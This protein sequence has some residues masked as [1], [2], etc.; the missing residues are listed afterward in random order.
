MVFVKGNRPWNF[1]NGQGMKGSRFYSIYH[2]ARKRCNNQKNKDYER[3]GGRGIKC[4]WENF[5][6]FKE[7]M[8]ESY[9]AH[10]SKHGT[11]ETTLDRID[12][13]GNYEKA[14][15]RWATW[16][17][18]GRNRAKKPITIRNSAVRVSRNDYKYIAEVRDDGETMS[19]RL[20][21][22]ISFYRKYKSK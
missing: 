20:S 15:C 19:K 10:E 21:T 6:H 8:Y 16:E 1:Q 12:N 18:Q 22:I 7:D 9:L 14:N 2:G 13:N 5:S 3:Y 17:V 11:R 4:L